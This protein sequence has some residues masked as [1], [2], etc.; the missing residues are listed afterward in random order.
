MPT[1]TAIR[2]DIYVGSSSEDAKKVATPYVEKGYR[3]IPNDALMIG[4]VSE[5]AGQIKLLEEQGFTD[6]IVR[7]ISSNQQECMA[8]IERL[9]EVKEQLA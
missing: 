3:G 2:R 6:I 5:V 4:S 9:S 7:N 1:A 8:C